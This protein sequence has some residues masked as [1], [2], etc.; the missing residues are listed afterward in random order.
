MGNADVD[1]LRSGGC[2]K[3]QLG[4][5]A[6]EMGH[7]VKPSVSEGKGRDD[8]FNSAGGADGMSHKGFGA[9]DERISFVDF[10]KSQ[11]PRLHH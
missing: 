2:R 4:D 11:L 10:L 6:F 7:A 1:I 9:V 8:C 5:G 3:V